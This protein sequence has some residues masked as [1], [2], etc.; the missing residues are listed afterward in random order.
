M[1]RAYIELINAD[2]ISTSAD[3][4]CNFHLRWFYNIGRVF[5]TL[6]QLWYHQYQLKTS[7]SENIDKNYKTP[8]NAQEIS[9][10]V[11]EKLIYFHKTASKLGA[12]FKL[13]LNWN[14]ES[15]EYLMPPETCFVWEK[16]KI[17]TSQIIKHCHHSLKKNVQ[18]LH[19]HPPLLRVHENFEWFY[20]LQKTSSMILDN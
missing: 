12:K 14:K 7:K 19:H 1:V 2:F 10:S 13:S 11:I 6:K 17:L 8:I 3:Q 9:I 4:K 18:N 5:S 15:R 16:L 20:R